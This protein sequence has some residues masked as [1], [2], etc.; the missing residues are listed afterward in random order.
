[1]FK[2]L[3]DKSV[4]ASS[5]SMAILWKLGKKIPKNSTTLMTYTILMTSSGFLVSY[6]HIDISNLFYSSCDSSHSLWHKL[7]RCFC[8]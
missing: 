1:V 4:S 2:A 8:S 7:Q 3:T 5:V 6:L